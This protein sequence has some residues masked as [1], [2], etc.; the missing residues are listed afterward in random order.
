MGEGGTQQHQGRR[1][2]PRPLA[3]PCAGRALPIF[4]HARHAPP[5]LP[6]R[7]PSVPPLAVR[8][9]VI[10][11]P[12]PLRPLARSKERSGARKRP[13]RRAEPPTT[14][15]VPS[16]CRFLAPHCLPRPVPYLFRMGRRHGPLPHYPALPPHPPTRTTFLFFDLRARKALCAKDSTQ[17]AAQPEAP[18]LNPV[19]S[20]FRVSF[21][22]RKRW[23]SA[24]PWSRPSRSPRCRSRPPALFRARTCPRRAARATVSR[25]FQEQPSRRLVTPRAE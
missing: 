24:L 11:A 4:T 19:F 23:P 9:G 13:S 20:L 21:S 18:L 5:D 1:R 3:R 17:Q 25:F 15:R 12:L 2:R 10:D 16:L 6:V 14:G 22:R 8:A 7:G